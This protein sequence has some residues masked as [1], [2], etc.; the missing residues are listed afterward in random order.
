MGV[1]HRSQNPEHPSWLM[2]CTLAVEDISHFRLVSGS[3]TFFLRYWKVHERRQLT[4]IKLILSQTKLQLSH[5]EWFRVCWLNVSHWVE[6]HLDCLLKES[7]LAAFS[8]IFSRFFF[9]GQTNKF[10]K[11][12]SN[13]KSRFA[14]RFGWRFT[15]LK[16]FDWRPTRP[17]Q[18]DAGGTGMGNRLRGDMISI[19]QKGQQVNLATNP[20]GKTSQMRI[21]QSHWVAAF[22][23]SSHFRVAK[24]AEFLLTN[25]VN[26][27]CESI[28]LTADP[29]GPPLFL[30]WYILGISWYTV[31]LN[32]LVF[33]SLCRCLTSLLSLLNSDAW[34]T[35]W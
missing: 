17:R 15:W 8:R 11:Q 28:F 7:Q 35:Q 20:N 1:I 9:G 4:I 19:L 23:F 13:W 33:F 24:T 10:E 14:P 12:S 22:S 16:W 3:I 34:G 18:I 6:S 32:S 5:F 21:R 30:I 31:Y 2:K 29:K 27:L 26:R 25:I